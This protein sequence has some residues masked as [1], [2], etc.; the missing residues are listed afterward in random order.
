MISVDHYKI[1]EGIYNM[2]PEG[3]KTLVSFGMIN[4]I[5]KKLLKKQLKEKFDG[6]IKAQ[7]DGQTPEEVDALTAAMGVPSGAVKRRTEFINKVSG[8]V[9][10]KIYSVAADKGAMAC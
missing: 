8:E 9:C 4:I 5:W 3:D 1:A 7:Y 2:M 6:I 10:K